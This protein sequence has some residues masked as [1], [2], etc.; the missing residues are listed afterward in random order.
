MKMM[1]PISI[2]SQGVNPFIEGRCSN[3][4]GSSLI[5]FQDFF[6]YRGG[7]PFISLCFD[8]CRTHLKEE[9]DLLINK[10]PVERIRECNDCGETFLISEKNSWANKCFNCWKIN[11]DFENKMKD[12][13]IALNTGMEDKDKDK[14]GNNNPKNNVYKNKAYN[15]MCSHLDFY[16]EKKEKGENIKEGEGEIYKIESFHLNETCMD[17]E[18]DRKPIK[19]KD[20]KEF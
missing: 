9:F 10:I 16:G 4:K 17:E 15:K 14:I 2:E 1:K 11:K 13:E 5:V 7:R 19:P 20:F 6:S 18:L 12:K 3:C 8:C